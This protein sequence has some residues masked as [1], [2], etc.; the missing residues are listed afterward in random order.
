MKTFFN[1]YA[2]R[3]VIVP[4]NH[5]FQILLMNLKSMMVP[6]LLV[7][8]MGRQCKSAA[9]LEMMSALRGWTSDLLKQPDSTESPD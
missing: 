1:F 4:Q 5:F 7:C 8:Q 9:G 3:Y 2:L 6:I